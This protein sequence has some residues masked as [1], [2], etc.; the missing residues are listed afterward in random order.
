M[1]KYVLIGFGFVL[2]FVMKANIALGNEKEKRA[3]SLAHEFVERL[4]KDD[5]FTYEEEKHFF[6]EMNEV[7]VGLFHLCGYL[8]NV[9]SEKASIPYFQQI[10]KEVNYSYLCELIR[11]FKP[12]LLLEG[13]NTV[14]FSAG[15]TASVDEKGVECLGWRYIYIFQ[16]KIPAIYGA[17][18]YTDTRIV[19]LNYNEEENT[20]SF[21]IIVNGRALLETM[22][23]RK[24]K[25]KGYVTGKLI[26]N[27]NTLQKLILHM[28]SLG[29]YSPNA[30]KKPK[31]KDHHLPE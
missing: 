14:T 29:Q 21:P 31:E 12:E 1:R 15:E 13:A 22:G 23:L 28:E 9:S 24:E 2:F 30:P 11:M 10:E 26:L 20:L 19:I 7:S 18:T 4:K 17:F 5:P 3:I 27:E 25:A 8:P 16:G 6:G